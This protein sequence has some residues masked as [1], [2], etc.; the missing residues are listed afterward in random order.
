VLSGAH[1]RAALAYQGSRQAG[2]EAGLTVLF[3]EDGLSEQDGLGKPERQYF[4]S[5]HYLGLISS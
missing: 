5:S 1:G 4:P 2:H 3:I